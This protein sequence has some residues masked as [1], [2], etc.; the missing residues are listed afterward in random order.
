MRVLCILCLWTTAAVAAPSPGDVGT[1]EHAKAT[2]LVKQ[3]GH[4]RYPV[5]EAAAKQLLEMGGA[6]ATALREGGKATDE[7]VRARCATLL[8][9]AVALDWQRKAEAYL[10][11]PHGRQTHALPLL[12]EFTKLV[13]KPDA[14]L[15]KLYAAMLRTNGPLFEAATGDPT[16][17]QKALADRVQLLLENHQVGTKAIK[18]DP[19]ELAAILFVHALDKKKPGGPVRAVMWGEA[20]PGR[21]L[22]NPGVA[23]AIADKTAGPAFRTLLARWADALPP[24]DGMSQQFF[25]MAARKHSIP[26]AAPA[27]VRA[28]KNTQASALS[29]RALAAE[30]LGKVGGADAIA[31]LESILTDRTPVIN[32]GGNRNESYQMGDAA[33]AALVAIQKKNRADYGFAS[34][35]NIGFAFGRGQEDIVMLN[36]QGFPSED[37]RKKAVEK[38]KSENP[39]GPGRPRRRRTRIRRGRTR[40]RRS[41]DRLGSWRFRHVV[42]GPP[43]H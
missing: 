29:V 9:Q 30:A 35:M 41:R 23:D 32:F 18:I 26:E 33:L 16:V 24:D 31:G 39:R 3:L 43:S 20:S 34:E 27:L 12:A 40:P 6:A 37:A 42:N 13:G 5:R 36:L 2:E 7:E 17:A 25:C 4:P 19:A 28:V 22:G 38:W 10:A 8:P 1:P 14:E 11:D 21:L 15:R